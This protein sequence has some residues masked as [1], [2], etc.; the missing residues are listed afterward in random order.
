MVLLFLEKNIVVGVFS[1]KLTLFLVS[2]G[3]DGCSGEVNMMGSVGSSSFGG[4]KLQ[5]EQTNTREIFPF[6]GG[7]ERRALAQLE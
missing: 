4:S 1:Q 5:L 2:K 6:R 7:R 3:D